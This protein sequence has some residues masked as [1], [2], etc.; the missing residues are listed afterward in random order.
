MEAVIMVLA[1]GAGGVYAAKRGR[2]AIRR[3]VGWTAERAGFITGRVQEALAETRRE[4]RERYDEGL[5]ATRARAD[6]KGEIGPASARPLNGAH[7][8]PPPSV[9]PPT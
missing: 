4:A 8:A 3:A 2:N 7:A 1:L 5:A 6:S 9:D